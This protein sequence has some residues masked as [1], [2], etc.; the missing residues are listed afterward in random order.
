MHGLRFTCRSERLLPWSKIDAH[1][2]AV[3][4]AS[5]PSAAEHIYR[6]VQT[7]LGE[8]IEE[9]PTG[10]SESLVMRI[11][12]PDLE[13]PRIVAEELRQG[14]TGNHASSEMRSRAKPMQRRAPP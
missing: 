1:H 7:Y 9:V 14:L 11:F 2:P 10:S 12:G 5:R 4:N 6:D 13:E 3:L 8:R